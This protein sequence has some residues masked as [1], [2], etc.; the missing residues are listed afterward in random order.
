[1]NTFTLVA[2]ITGLIIVVW[3]RRKRKRAEAQKAKVRELPTRSSAPVLQTSEMPVAETVQRAWASCGRAHRLVADV[4]DCE[5]AQAAY[6]QA[7]ESLRRLAGPMRSSMPVQERYVLATTTIR[8][9]DEAI[10]K[11]TAFRRLSGSA[12]R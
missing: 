2:L 3:R 4:P 8:Q 7:I 1:M 12:K 6:R 5:P 10:E 11:A 9:A